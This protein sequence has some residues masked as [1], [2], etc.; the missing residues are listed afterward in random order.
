VRVPVNQIFATVSNT[1]IAGS[2]LYRFSAGHGGLQCEACH[3]S[4]HA[5][6]PATHQNDNVRN[7][8]IQGHAGVMVECTACHVT[9]NA[10]SSTYTNG[11]HGMHPIGQ[12]WVTGHHDVI[13]ETQTGQCRACHGLDYRGTPLSRIQSTNSITVNRDG[14]VINFPTF[15]GAEV[16]CYNCHNGPTQ[17]SA[18]TNAN[19]TAVS[20]ATN[21]LNNQP[22]VFVLP[23]GGAG[24]NAHIT[25]QPAHGS[26][27]LSNNVATYFPEAGFVGTDT[28]AFAAWNGSKNSNLATGSVAVAQGPFSLVAKAYAPATYPSK[29]AAPFTVMATP[30]NANAA[31]TF[32]WD[33]GDGSTHATNQYPA[34]TYAVPGSYQ[35]SV[36]V[37]VRSG[38]VTATTNLS[39]TIVIG[40]PVSLTVKPGAG[41]VTLAWP[42]TS[43]D[44]L[45]E[46]SP[47]LGAGANWVVVS[48]APITSGGTVTVSL[49]PTGNQFFRLRRL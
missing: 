5:E 47:V 19:P 22:I 2:W 26:V 12:A 4:T 48:N 40:A 15:K 17:S 8:K 11:P 39:G 18:N 25:A 46:S 33:F 20:V 10:S 43:G 13:N 6:F 34:H 21:T 28:F 44:A 9:M 36:A 32:N 45:L 49:P 29:W 41:S 16:G 42:L 30:I 24:A 7:E 23:V 3:G 35:W 37:S 1:P 27:G 38:A 31:P 14:I